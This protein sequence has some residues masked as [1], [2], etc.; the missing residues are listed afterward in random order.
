MHAY[1]NDTLLLLIFLTF[2]FD[3][4]GELDM[5]YRLKKKKDEALPPKSGRK[6]M[7]Y[8]LSNLSTVSF[9]YDMLLGSLALKGRSRDRIQNEHKLRADIKIDRHT[10]PP[11]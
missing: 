5:G 10:Y 8:P 1:E 9:T 4:K 3:R 2:I 7:S 11:K 6:R